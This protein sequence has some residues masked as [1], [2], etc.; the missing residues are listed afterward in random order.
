M[1]ESAGKRFIQFL[2]PCRDA[3]YTQALALA[4]SPVAAER[5]IQRSLRTA[6][7]ENAMSLPKGD[8]QAWLM[9][10]INREAAGAAGAAVTAGGVNDAKASTAAPAMTDELTQSRAMPAATWA[11]LAAAI[12]IEAAKLAEDGGTGEAILAYDPLLEPKKKSALADE[13]LEGFGLSASARFIIGGS[14][15]IAIGVIASIVLT[16]H[17]APPSPELPSKTPAVQ[18]PAATM[19]AHAAAHR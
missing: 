1:I 14:I 16:T 4:G 12:Q 13:P 10:Q 3:L 9:S 2:E 18:P 8:L 17:K 11:R 15:V 19:P 5:L 7:R 6:F